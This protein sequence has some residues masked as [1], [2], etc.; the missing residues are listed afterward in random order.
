MH[1]AGLA[2]QA[3]HILVVLIVL[4]EAKVWGDELYTTGGRCCDVMVTWYCGGMVRLSYT[5]PVFMAG[6]CAEGKCLNRHS[7]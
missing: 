7:W 2:A 3:R 1:A 6:V 4:N 5:V